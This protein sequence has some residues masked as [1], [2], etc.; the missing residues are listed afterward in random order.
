MIMHRIPI[1]V[2]LVLTLL[3]AGLTHADEPFVFPETRAGEIASDYFEAFNSGDLERLR[4]HYQDYRSEASLAERS[5]DERASAT[6]GL[7]EQ[8]GRLVPAR[9]TNETEFSITITAHAEKVKMWASCLF[10]LEEQEPYKLDMLMIGPGSP[11]EMVTEGVKT[12]TSLTDLLDQVRT[13][14]GL[15]AI[16]VAVI[17]DGG[18]IQTAAVGIRK[19]GSTD[20]IEIDDRFHIG[21]ITKSVTATMIGRL[22]EKGLLAWDTTIARTLEDIEIREE[23]RDVTLEQLLQHRAGLPGYLTFEDSTDARLIA[24]PGT[25]TEQR[26]VFV[27]EVLQTE[28]IARA[29]EDMNYSNAGYVVA[30]LMA[31]QVSGTG[32]ENLVKQ[33]VLD[34]AGMKNSG[35]GWPATEARPG[36]PYGHFY[37]DSDFRPQGMDEYPLGGFIAPA[38]DIHTS[39]GDLALYAKLHMDGLA[40]RDGVVKASTI[41]YLHSPPESKDN[42][43]RYAGGWMLVEKEGLGT[44]HTHSGSAGTFY[45]TVELYPEEN[46]ATAVVTNAGAGAGAV[47]SIIRSIN[48][49]AKTGTP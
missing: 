34:P 3:A 2:P 26:R 49:V 10:Q 27:A 42:E 33:Y 47:E 45:A 1:V 24:L 11:P 41:R 46:R 16:A 7:Y 40:G 21:S 19:A 4:Q 29:G 48:E 17:E 20:S 37:E 5:P 36:Q 15:P 31:E 43:V 23:Y 35:F 28:P 39:I 8:L 12:W 13:D 18:V 32:W 44:V 14:T 38:G 22:V 9:V 25:P 30:G 6:L